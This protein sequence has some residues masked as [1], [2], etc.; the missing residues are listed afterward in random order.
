MWFWNNQS[1]DIKPMLGRWIGVSHRVRSALCY[2]ML[3]DKGKVLS[4]TTVQHLTV[5]QPR[6]LCAQYQIRD[7]HVSLEDVFGSKDFDTSLDGYE[8][9]IDDYEEVIAKG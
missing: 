9:S 7:Y 5:E 1:D 2:C 8:S 3:S 6:D 4:I